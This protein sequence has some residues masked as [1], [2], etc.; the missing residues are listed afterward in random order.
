MKGRRFADEILHTKAGHL[1]VTFLAALL[2]SGFL[3]LPIFRTLY[4]DNL[5][6]RA[7]LDSD[8]FL[9]TDFIPSVEQSLFADGDF[10]GDAIRYWVD[11][12]S[13]D[14]PSFTRKNID[15]KSFEEL[16]DRNESFL[17]VWGTGSGSNVTVEEISSSQ[18]SR[19]ALQR[20]ES[21]LISELNSLEGF[22]APSESGQENTSK[23]GYRVTRFLYI[24]PTNV[25]THAAFLQ[26]VE[27]FAE[28][29]LLPSTHRVFF[30]AALAMI[31]AFALA[32]KYEKQSQ[33]RHVRFFLNRSFEVKYLVLSIPALLASRVAS[34]YII[35]YPDTVSKIFSLVGYWMVFIYVDV[36]VISIKQMALLGFRRTFYSAT[37]N[38]T[39]RI[40]SFFRW[41]GE[42]ELTGGLPKTVL[43]ILFKVTAW[44][45]LIAAFG[46]YGGILF[47]LG[48]LLILW[49][50]YEAYRRSKNRK[51]IEEGSIKIVNGQ[52]DYQIDETVYP[53]ETIAR[54][55]NNIRRG[56]KASLESQVKSERM[57][58][59]LI[60]NVSHD[61]KTPLT[62]II[63]Y[64]DLIQKE[65]LTEDERMEYAQIIHDKSRRLKLLI[66]DLFEVSKMSS[67]QIELHLE[68]LDLVELL[69]QSIGEWDGILQ[70]KGIRLVVEESEEIPGVLDGE[71]TSRVFE[72]LLSNI[73]K[74]A[75][76]N[77]RTYIDIERMTDK[78]QI[79]FKNIAS[80]EMNFKG[81]D[82]KE[83]FSRGDISRATEGSGLGLAI[84][85]NI[86][87]MQGG[88]LDIIVDGDLY[89]AVVTLPV[90]PEKREK[91]TKE[92]S[93]EVQKKTWRIE[94]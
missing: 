61:L 52:Y 15:V 67:G 20:L 75:M 21:S 3:F 58:T 40:V 9:T 62:S 85:A 34:G 38:L 88:S 42:I 72:N 32:G 43:M 59:E 6:I 91:E 12:G 4:P 66:D 90:L 10:S 87:E 55:F 45:L 94:T 16:R 89:K 53:Y 65:G 8:V 54:N 71:R 37:V 36:L 19:G 28:N 18:L 31:V 70:R 39:K 60:T 83:R 24:L 73:S 7:Y 49:N 84:A 23:T 29:S 68:R 1:I 30:V 74:Y 56:L 11:F 2:C 50:T 76:E 46:F 80:Y 14:G 35:S 64:S 86:C 26:R 44:Y 13:N 5:Q 47:P 25:M 92:T 27:R 78:A 77:T 33:V 22:P 93:R 82:M 41:L 48:V 51:I 63:N 17:F 79:V 81:E 69:R 57:K